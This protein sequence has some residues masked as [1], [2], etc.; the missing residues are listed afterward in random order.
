MEIRNFK[1]FVKIVKEEEFEGVCVIGGQEKHLVKKAVDIILNKIK[2]FP[3]LNVSYF[4]GANVN[5][6]EIINSCET[7]P[8]LSDKK[9]IYIQN[10]SNNALMAIGE[11]LI[12]YCKNIPKGIILLITLED[13]VDIKNKYLNVI[14]NIGYIIEFNQLRGDELNKFVI[15]MLGRYG[16][17]INKSELIYL[18][19]ETGSSL[20]SLEMEIQKLVCYAMDEDVITKEHIDSIVTRTLESNVFKMVDCI[21]KKDADNAL[22]ILN[23]LLFQ[24]EEHLKI[25]AMII[26]QYRL[27][28]QTKLALVEKLNIN[29]IKSGL[30]LKD[31]MIQNLIRQC[32]IY[33]IQDIKNAL[34][35][36][37]DVDYSIKTNR[38]SNDLALELLIV[39]LCK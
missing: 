34:R 31:F 8:F 23:N 10:I 33:S 6:N 30:K 2:N 37:L 29:E 26:R 25:L 4:E 38:I 1:E 16:K 27:L 28:L 9:I 17:L 14:K 39:N 21:A 35:M 12:E 11:N 15:D 3:E 36:C 13:D 20:E 19:S 32:N 24:K 18:L 5:F 22:T 7:L